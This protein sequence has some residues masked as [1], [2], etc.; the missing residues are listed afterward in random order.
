MH[1]FLRALFSKHK[2]KHLPRF[3][4]DTWFDEWMSYG[5]ITFLTSF[6]LQ[7]MLY[8]NWR[9]N[10]IKIALDV[11]VMAALILSGLPWWIAFLIAHTV[12]YCINGQAICVFYH[13]RA[14]NLTAQQFYEGTVKMK[15]RL[16]KCKYLDAA[17]SYGSLSTGKWH[18]SSDIDIRF[19]PKRGELNYWLAM[20]W[21][22]GERTRAFFNGYPLDMYVFTMK[23]SYDVMSKN[24][25]PIVF[26]DLQNE[27][28][29]YYQTLMSFEDFKVMFTKMHLNK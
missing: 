8:A 13:I 20:F 9:D 12:N 26:K 10:V 6:I 24:E 29:K 18:P 2:K 25:V 3:L 22:V 23:H 1:R 21:S 7:G 17:I 4:T 28:P 11:I 19:I 14:G 27:A 15:E 16:D 5:Y